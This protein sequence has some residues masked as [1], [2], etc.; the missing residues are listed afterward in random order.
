M[1]FFERVL[2]LLSG[3]S[4]CREAISTAFARF[5]R[6]KRARVPGVVLLAYPRLLFAFLIA[7]YDYTRTLVEKGGEREPGVGWCILATLLCCGL[8]LISTMSSDL[9]PR[10]HRPRSMTNESSQVA[11]PRKEC[12]TS[13]KL[14]R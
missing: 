4:L 1:L 5:R 8:V 3:W 12:Y 13:A 10:D 6:R 9:A 14:G 7:I 11:L 2:P